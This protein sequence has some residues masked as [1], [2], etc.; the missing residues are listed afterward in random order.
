MASKAAQ[1]F[2]SRKI[3]ILKKEGNRPHKQI[4]A[5]AL[6]MARKKG[7]KV[8]KSS[9]KKAIKRIKSRNK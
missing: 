6:S 1:K 7:F 4:I 3:R 9:K 8:S 5:I 2:I